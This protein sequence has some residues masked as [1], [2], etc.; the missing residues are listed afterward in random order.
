MPHDCET[1]R[2]YDENRNG[3]HCGGCTSTDDHWEASDESDD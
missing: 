1:C 3:P 2:W